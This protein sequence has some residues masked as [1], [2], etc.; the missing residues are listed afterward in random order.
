[1]NFIMSPG[2]FWFVGRSL[3][4]GSRAQ[5]NLI[6]M[7]TTATVLRCQQMSAMKK[8][9]QTQPLPNYGFS[10]PS[11]EGS[12]TSGSKSFSK[13]TNR[14]AQSN[15]F[16]AET[17]ESFNCRPALG[18]NIV[19]AGAASTETC[20][21]VAT[22]MQAS[23]AVLSKAGAV[24]GSHLT[25]QNTDVKSFAMLQDVR[26]RTKRSSKA[27]LVDPRTSQR[28][29]LWDAITS[30]A[31]I[32]T[33]FI[34]PYE[35]AF[36][37]MATSALDVLFIINR[38]TDLIFIID[39]AINFR[40][41]F[42]LEG[43]G[44]DGSGTVWVEDPYQIAKHYAQGWLPIDVLSIGAS[45][46]DFVGLGSD[47]TGDVSGL[48]ALR[49]LRALRLIKLTRLLRASRIFR[50]WESQFAINYKVLELA[51]CLT[52]MLVVAHWFACFWSLQCSLFS[53]TLLD[54]WMGNT[55]Y[56]EA[57]VA[58]APC[59][60]EFE[61]RAERPGVACRDAASLYAASVYWAV[62][63]ITSIGYGDIGAT[64]YN[65]AEQ[66]VCTL[67]MLLGAILWGYVI[68]TFCGTIANLSPATQEFRR[69]LDDLNT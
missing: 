23:A 65:A 62:M 42:A 37:P 47:G 58:G 49:V 67:Q 30:T 33:A 22:T 13:S 32:F 27:F 25:R 56:C 51:K 38:L 48:R 46:V 1:M 68:G 4:E 9:H 59:P 44:E 26:R 61:C 69:N 53:S 29:P 2:A 14:E 60:A 20:M 57:H 15:S 10:S 31:I 64:P 7:T 19:P 41:V 50:R 52:A 6:A 66:I 21:D 28:L 45:S 63:T 54:S 12:L 5:P 17:A 24:C 55:G 40:L 18:A 8:R 36:L 34:T 35:V 16:R 3:L 39:L 43:D 11:V